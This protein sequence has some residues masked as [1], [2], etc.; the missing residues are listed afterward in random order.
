MSEPI[1][2]QEE[3]L[4]KTKTNV[5]EPS[6]KNKSWTFRD[7]RDFKLEVNADNSWNICKEQVTLYT[8][9]SDLALYEIRYI[10]MAGEEMQE[11]KFVIK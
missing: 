6:H 1:C 3:F 10:M 11:K 9:T 7:S 2:R 8:H 5:A 4:P